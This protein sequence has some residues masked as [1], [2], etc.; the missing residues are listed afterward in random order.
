SRVHTRLEETPGGLTIQPEL[1]ALEAADTPTFLQSDTHWNVRGR[2]AFARAVLD[3]VRPGL[4]AEARLRAL[5]ATDRPG[6]LGVFIGQER[7]DRDPMLTVTGTPKATF[8]PGEVLFVG[9][10]QLDAALRTA[11]ADGATVLDRVFPGQ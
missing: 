10:S 8:A 9:D 1:D 3:A 7:I 2:E 6:D 5:E 4:A 11:G